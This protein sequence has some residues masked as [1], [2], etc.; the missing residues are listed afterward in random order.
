MTDDQIKTDIANHYLA[1]P[2]EHFE[3]WLRGEAEAHRGETPES[4]YSVFLTVYLDGKVERL[5]G[6]ARDHASTDTV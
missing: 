3:S 2:A 5:E 1:M 4:L 6:W